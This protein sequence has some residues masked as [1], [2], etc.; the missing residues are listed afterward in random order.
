MISAKPFFLECKPLN[1]MSLKRKS[2]ERYETVCSG[3]PSPNRR[4]LH[5]PQDGFDYVALRTYFGHAVL[6]MLRKV[7]GSRRTHFPVGVMVHFTD[8]DRRRSIHVR[9]L[10]SNHMEKEKEK[11]AI[12]TFVSDIRQTR[13]VMKK[14]GICFLSYRKP[15][16]NSNDSKHRTVLLCDCRNGNNITLSVIDSNGVLSE[17][18]QRRARIVL[19][20]LFSEVLGWQ[21]KLIIKMMHIPKLNVG[22][23]KVRNLDIQLGI[24]DAIDPEGYCVMASLAIAFDIL[25][26]DTQALSDNHFERLIQD[27]VGRCENCPDDVKNYNRLMALRSFTFEIIMRMQKDGM[28]PGPLVFEPSIIEYDPDRAMDHFPPPPPPPYSPRKSM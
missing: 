23:S 19:K 6:W 20:E 8:D 17:K 9:D 22:P 11:R 25:C 28:W 7:I 2:L 3:L 10:H 18:R 26:T 13:S 4:P 14:I 16:G 24:K 15:R 21:G 12:A 1:A 5:V 27:F